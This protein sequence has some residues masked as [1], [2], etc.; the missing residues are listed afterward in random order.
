MTRPEDTA[1]GWDGVTLRDWFAGQVIAS[2]KSWH[3]TDRRGKSSAQIAYEIADAM[4]AERD[5][6]PEEITEEEQQKAARYIRLVALAW[7]EDGRADDCFWEGWTECPTPLDDLTPR[8]I[9]MAL[10]VPVP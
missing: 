5:K 2:V 9:L 7:A 10:G 6:C 3:P 8:H 4:L 1:H